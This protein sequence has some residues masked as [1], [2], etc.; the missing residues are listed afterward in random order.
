MNKVYV[1]IPTLNQYERLD[2][3]IMSI[4]NGT[5][6]PEK[7]IIINNG[8]GKV[9]ALYTDKKEIIIPGYN[10]GCSASWN[11]FLKTYPDDI[12]LI[13]NDDLEFYPDTL[14]KIINTYNQKKEDKDI[15][16]F[17]PD[18]GAHSI[19]SCFIV[20]K[21]CVERVGYFDEEFYP[22]YYEDN[23]Y[24]R[25]FDMQKMKVC[26]AENCGYIHHKSS[27]ISAY[28]AEQHRNHSQTF[29]KNADYYARKWGGPPHHETFMTPFNK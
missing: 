24:V 14:E 6:K 15:G 21:S 27:T 19:F 25:R 1:C 16:L 3:L 11:Y 23:D 26:S 13:V 28:T 7:Y 8:I 29:N 18:H 12:C 9:S 2:K 4:E 22:A 17:F 5:M 20:S 10:M